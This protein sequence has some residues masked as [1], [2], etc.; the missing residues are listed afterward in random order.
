MWYRVGFFLFALSPLI[1][2]GSALAAPCAA[3]GG[4]FVPLECI[5]NSP[6][7]SNLYGS[8]DFSTYLSRI[9]SALIAVGAIAAALRLTWAG[10]TYAMSDLPGVKT[11]AKD[12]IFQSIGGLVLLLSIALILYQINPDILKM[13][14]LTRNTPS[15]VCADGRAC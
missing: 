10:F 13:K 9:F 2:A 1:L 11:S 12:H 15:P 8:G 3:V 14:F 6:R 4:G 5:Q 7:L